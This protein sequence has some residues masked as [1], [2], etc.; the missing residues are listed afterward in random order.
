[1]NRKPF[2]KEQ[3]EQFKGYFS[4][5]PGRDLLSLFMEWCESKDI[6]GKDK[7]YIWKI[8]R[9]FKPIEEK[10]IEKGSEEAIRIGELINVIF[11][12]DLEKLKKIAE[13]REKE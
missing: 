11:G 13:K 4:K 8:A 9:H 2:Y 1:M 6:E 5:Y 7:H 10:E 12:A 3:A